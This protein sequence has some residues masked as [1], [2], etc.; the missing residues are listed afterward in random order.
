MTT[1]QIFLEYIINYA[2]L[3]VGLIIAGIILWWAR[4][5]EGINPGGNHP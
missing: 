2:P 4:M 5:R 3:F 1:P